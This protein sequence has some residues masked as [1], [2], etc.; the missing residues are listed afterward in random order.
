MVRPAPHFG[1]FG[2]IANMLRLFWFGRLLCAGFLAGGFAPAMA[3]QFSADIV[4]T[5][6]GGIVPAGRLSVRDGR[7]RI[8]TPE[9]PNGFLLVDV[10]KPSAYFVRPA[11]HIYM[12]ARQSSRLSQLFVPVDPDEPCRR[13]QAMAELAGAAGQAEWRCE[14]AGQEEI[15]GRDAE[16]VRVTSAEP[17]EFVAWIDRERRFPLRIKTA[18]G[19]VIALEHIRDEAQPAPLFELPPDARKFSP[20]ALIERI[21]QSDVWVS[22]PTDDEPSRR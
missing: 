17:R 8:E 7:V 2:W 10:A 5:R 9:L 13:W 15:K 1:V 4:M 3:Q 12:D 21:K 6:D 16:M 11:T 14:H 19:A 20:E 22:E 18:E